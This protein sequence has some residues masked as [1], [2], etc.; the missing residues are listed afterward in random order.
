MKNNN[1][2]QYVKQ[3]LELER[4]TQVLIESRRNCASG[5]IDRAQLHADEL[6]RERRLHSVLPQ[7]DLL[8]VTALHVDTGRFGVFEV[9]KPEA[10]FDFENGGTKA[11]D[12]LQLAQAEGALHAERIYKAG[13]ATERVIDGIAKSA[14]RHYDDLT[15]GV[16]PDEDLAT[17]L[18]ML[19]QARNSTMEIDT[20]KGRI[21]LGGHEHLKKTL[22]CRTTYRALVDVRAIDDDG[23][24]NGTLSFKIH[25]VESTSTSLPDILSSKKRINAALSTG[26]DSRALGLVHFSKLHQIP[27]KLELELEYQIEDRDWTIKVAGI[28]DEEDLLAKDRPAQAVFADW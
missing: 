23:K 5:W 1:V 21:I 6:V 12:P 16:R 27:I 18:N 26:S 7:S 13:R 25:Q 19:S 22:P 9:V 8:L 10:E 14:I 17:V 20:L 11:A 24:P 15:A 2:R 28:L 4:M 3:M